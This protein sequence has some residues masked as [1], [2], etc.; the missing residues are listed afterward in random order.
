MTAVHTKTT[1]NRAIVAAIMAGLAQGDTRPF[2]AAMREDFTWRHMA[3]SR[4]GK[5]KSHYSGRPA[6]RAFFETLWTQLEGR[7]INTAERIHADGDFVIVESKGAVTT[8][9]GKPYNNTYCMV[10]EMADG[11]IVEV[12]EYMDSALADAILEPIIA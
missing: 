11:K 9:S 2:A 6:V 10:F 1:E 3:A 5:W 4:S 12:R 7:T 8:R